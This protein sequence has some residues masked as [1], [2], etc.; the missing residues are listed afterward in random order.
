MERRVPI[1]ETQ[2]ARFYG[3]S[4]PFLWVDNI[5]IHRYVCLR[6]GHI[7]TVQFAPIKR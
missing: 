7:E 2:G 5:E 6:C 4:E 3:D 1:L